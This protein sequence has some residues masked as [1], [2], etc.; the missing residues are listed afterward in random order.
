[1]TATTI[2]NDGANRACGMV[3]AIHNGLG[4]RTSSSRN[5]LGLCLA[6]CTGALANSAW[7]VS[8]SL[9]APSNSVIAAPATI[10]LMAKATPGAGRRILRVNFFRGTTRIGTDISAPYGIT[11][12]NVPRGTYIL[13]ASAIDSGGSV[14]VSNQ[15]VIR[16]DTPPTV[17]LTSPA[18]NAV[19]TP[20]VNI[21]LAASATDADEFVT[22]VEFFSGGTLLGT[23]IVSPYTFDWSNVPSGKYTLTA[24]ATDLVGL[25]STSA[26]VTITVDA[27]SAVSITSPANDARFVS[28][29]A[30]T[31][32]ATAVDADGSISQ[33]EFFDGAT[34]I[35]TVLTIPDRK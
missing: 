26:P 11:W 17:S 29:A 12:S 18:D 1:M 16:V 14:A 13:S 35:G 23:Q 4:R 7:A 27:P 15:V 21:P 30:V 6:L 24:R 19:F 31:I 3:K 25:V 32:S 5:L 9:T 22:K 28:S 8:V 2:G 33:I 10:T 34:P 20:G